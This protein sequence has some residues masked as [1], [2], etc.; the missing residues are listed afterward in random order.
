LRDT[1]MKQIME[2]EGTKILTYVEQKNWTN[3]KLYVEENSEMEPIF[4][5]GNKTNFK[6]NM[7]S[8]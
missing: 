6:E 2:M 3:G 5:H 4:T 8:N 1:S 7:C